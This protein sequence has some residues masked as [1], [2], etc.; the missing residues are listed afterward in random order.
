MSRFLRTEEPVARRVPNPAELKPV[1]GWREVR[2]KY[3]FVIAERKIL[4]M[5][6]EMLNLEIKCFID[7]PIN[8][9]IQ[10][11]RVLYS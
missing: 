9:E 2:Q 6:K 1:R 10:I 7:C 8:L 3:L 4:L 11:L 5:V